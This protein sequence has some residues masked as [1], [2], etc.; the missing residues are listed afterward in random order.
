[1]DNIVFEQLLLTLMKDVKTEPE[2][3][4]IA[5]QLRGTP[6]FSNITD[7]EFEKAFEHAADT[8]N[9]FIGK[10]YSIEEFDHKKWFRNFYKNLSHTRWDRYRDYLRVIK[11]FASNVITRMEENLFDITD[12]LGNPKGDNFSRKGLIVGDVQSGKT[13]NYVGLM[14]LATDVGYNIIIVLTG[15]TNTLREQTQIRIE[16]GLGKSSLSEGV[17]RIQNADYK[18]FIGKDPIYLTSRNDDFSKSRAGTYG[19]SLGSNAVPII[20]VTKKNVN[21]LKNIFGWLEKYSKGK[22]DNMIDSSLL[23]IDDEADFASVNTGD[24]TSPTAINRSIRNILALFTKSSY[25]GFTATPY[26]NVFINP[27]TEEDMENQDI[28][29]KDYIYVLGESEKYIGIQSVFSDDEKVGVNNFMLVPINDSEVE[30][31][32]PL[33]HKKKDTFTTLPPSMKEAVNLFLIAN[34]IRDMRKHTKSHRSMLI[35]ASR[36][37]HMHEQIQ[38]VVAEYL[39]TMQKVIRINGRLSAAEALKIPEIASLKESFEKAYAHLKDGYSFD[40]ILPNMNESIYA[41][42][43]EIVNAEKENKGVNYQATEEKGEYERVII[44]GGFA[45]SRGLTLEGLMISYYW[46]NSVMYDS[47]LQMGRWFGYR[48]GYQ[49]LCRIFMSRDVISD[50]KFIAT[51]TAELKSD[52]A[53]NSHKGLTPKQFGIRVRT[54][55]AGLIITARNKMKTGET[56]TARATFSKDIIETTSFSV[57]NKE[58]NDKNTS[59][60]KSIVHENSEQLVID[61]SGKHSV[62]ELKDIPKTKII[63]FLDNFVSIPGSRFDGG[64]IVDW[65]NENDDSK[66]DNWDVFFLNGDSNVRYHYGHDISGNASERLVFV[67]TKPIVEGAV[68]NNKARL[69][70]PRDGRYGMNQVQRELE[71]EIKEE[72]YKDKTFPQKEYFR[73]EFNRKPVILIYSV[74]PK[75]NSEDVIDKSLIEAVNNTNPIPLLSVEIP[76]LDEKTTKYVNY[77]VNKIYQ[78]DDV[79]VECDEE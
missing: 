42:H 72:F 5:L 65:L 58:A 76:E 3:R 30:T 7:E 9:V 1:M 57:T 12:L 14:N 63:K 15:T 40:E 75:F 4:D 21:A 37:I 67:P 19:A 43:A 33:K 79:E 46:R 10:S 28:F 68:K 53:R 44:I 17:K 41:V 74:I 18:S 24:D 23:L 38:S 54:G 26:A 47:L 49:D 61:D 11:G 59:L 69:A 66:L 32:L 16:E 8:L 73:A 45:L 71:K 29:P 22:N 60:I 31:Y 52:L 62:Y 39:S 51:A 48:P 64:L 35:N 2:L 36:F 20:I 34:T 13:A 55:Q 70:S 25:I 78:N 56:I 6:M 27:E 50:Y 77:T